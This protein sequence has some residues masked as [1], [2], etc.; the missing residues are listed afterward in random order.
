MKFNVNTLLVILV[1]RVAFTAAFFQ[2]IS[3]ESYDETDRVRFEKVNELRQKANLPELQYSDKLMMM[4][5][6]AVEKI[7]KNRK[8]ESPIPLYQNKKLHAR[9]LKYIGEIATTGCKLF[10]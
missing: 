3:L 4:A 2:R 9:V 1:S 6:T 10:V 5:Q 7:A 8:M